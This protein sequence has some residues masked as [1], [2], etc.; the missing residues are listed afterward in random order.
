M[1]HLHMNVHTL[2]IIDRIRIVT[3]LTLM[4]FIGQ[5]FKS[6]NSLLTVD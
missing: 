5:E 1:P 6:I 2:C 3:T 4:H